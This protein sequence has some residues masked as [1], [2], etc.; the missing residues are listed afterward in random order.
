MGDS[1]R[2]NLAHRDELRQAV[3]RFTVGQGT[4]ADIKGNQELPSHINIYLFGPQGSGKTSFI[5]TCFRALYGLRP[6]R[7]LSE[8]ETS[9]HRTDDGT[10]MYSVFSLTDRVCLHDT[11]GQ[12]EYTQEEMAQLKLVLEGRAKPSSLIQQRRRYW[13]L[14]REFW[15]NDDQMRKTFSRTVM[16]PKA[17]LDTEPHFAFLVIDPNQQELLL[18]DEDFRQ[19]YG[20]LLGD[21]SDRGVPHALLCTHGD[22]LTPDLRG[23]LLKLPA[24]M[25]V[26]A[27]K[28]E[29]ADP[30]P[31]GPGGSG[32]M[33][34]GQPTAGSGPPTYV[35]PTNFQRPPGGQNSGGVAAIPPS[36]SSPSGGYFEVPAPPPAAPAPFD[37]G[38]SQ[39]PRSGTTKPPANA[40][41]EPPAKMPDII[42]IVTNYTATPDLSRKPPP[43][44][45]AAVELDQ[46]GN[47]VQRDIHSLLVLLDALHQC[48]HQIL[49]RVMGQRPPPMPQEAETGCPLL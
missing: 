30:G 10:S 22:T 47:D 29:G 13:L 34:P 15:R 41:P 6:D 38:G 28:A 25:S 45:K 8:A 39:A 11:R 24:A 37:A 2:A 9:L 43:G 42:R 49:Q 33:R 44:P 14:L 12:R 21:F 3:L 35:P 17:T 31:P 32:V 16:L 27:L 40:S 1:L 23:S 5:R 7:E 26:R 20:G 46:D 36:R 18:E 19:C 4:N 48:D